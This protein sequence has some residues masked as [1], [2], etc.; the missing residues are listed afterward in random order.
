M[1]E[2]KSVN[3]LD[4]TDIEFVLAYCGLLVKKITSK[5]RRCRVLNIVHSN[6][7]CTASEIAKIYTQKYGE[8]I[9][10]STLSGDLKE[11]VYYDLCKAAPCGKRKAYLTT[12]FVT[13]LCHLAVVVKS[14]QRAV[15]FFEISKQLKS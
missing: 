7:L 9:R 2:S 14:S 11:L 13:Q 4:L 10:P 5:P 8:K 1:C 3:E 12:G 6:P 15:K